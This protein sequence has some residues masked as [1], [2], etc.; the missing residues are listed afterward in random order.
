MVVGP[1]GGGKSVVLNSL[2]ATQTAM[3][4]PTKMTIINPKMIPVSE[5][6]GELDPVACES[7]SGAV[8]QIRS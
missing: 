3:G 4:L 1:T 8:Q 6:Y 5:L 7:A 2:C